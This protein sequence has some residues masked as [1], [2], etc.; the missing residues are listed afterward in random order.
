MENLTIR[1]MDK[2]FLTNAAI[3]DIYAKV[4][5]ITSIS[6]VKRRELG[7]E[8]LHC[9]IVDHLF[10]FLKYVDAWSSFCESNKLDLSAF[11]ECC[12]D[13]VDITDVIAKLT[14]ND[15]FRMKNKMVDFL[16]RVRISFVECNDDSKS[17]ESR[18]NAIKYLCNLNNY[19]KIDE[20]LV[21]MTKEINIISILDASDIGLRSEGLCTRYQSPVG[22]IIYF[23]PN[24]IKS[25]YMLSVLNTFTDQNDGTSL[26]ESIKD[27]L[28]RLQ[29]A[30]LKSPENDNLNLEIS[31]YAKTFKSWSFKFG[32]IIGS[33]D[34]FERFPL[35]WREKI[36]EGVQKAKQFQQQTSKK[37]NA[38][39]EPLC[40]GEDLFKKEVISGLKKEEKEGITHRVF[41][42]IILKSIDS[43][44]FGHLCQEDFKISKMF[45]EDTLSTMPIN[46]KML[47]RLVARHLNVQELG[48]E[49]DDEADTDKVS[50]N[51]GLDEILKND[52]GDDKNGPSPKRQ[53]VSKEDAPVKSRQPIDKMISRYGKALTTKFFRPSELF[54][55]LYK[56]YMGCKDDQERN[57]VDEYYKFYRNI[58]L[59]KRHIVLLKFSPNGLN[60]GLNAIKG[61]YAIEFTG[62]LLQPSSESNQ[63][64][65]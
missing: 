32:P 60:Q 11:D 12:D 3:N 36:K 6:S 8:L 14:D 54:H 27:D 39:V 4:M 62:R 2:N 58:F 34:R 64:H 46:V 52:D 15:S 31:N 45:S 65:Q 63:K 38:V 37:T 20:D 5:K 51:E 7:F 1:F 9:L 19:C 24:K 13:K 50:L 43:L 33:G 53:R 18:I 57:D 55:E 56:I 41:L 35:V 48:D 61:D 23:D 16:F 25:I 28:F 17:Y 44:N 30:N 49:A 29:F 22:E 40:V 42:Y 26:P 10:S 59:N 47:G 21:Q